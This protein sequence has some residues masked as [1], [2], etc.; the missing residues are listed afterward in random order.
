MIDEKIL[1]GTT[2]GLWDVGNGECRRFEG[3]EVQSLSRDDSGLMAIID[4]QQIWQSRGDAEW[5]QIAT[6]ETLNAVCLLSTAAGILVGTSEARLFLLRDGTLQPVRSFDSVEDRGN[7][8]TPWGGPPNVRSMAADPSGSLYVNVH[9]GG[10]VRSSDELESWQHTIDI[11]ADVHQVLHDSGSSMLLAATG[12][13]FAISADNGE[14]WGFHTEGLHG[15][16][17]RAI[18]VAGDTVLITASTG[19][20]TRKSAVYRRAV[21]SEE[22]F[23]RCRGGLPEWFSDNINTFC[24]AALDSSVAFGTTDGQVYYSSDEGR[25]WNAI[26]EEIPRILCVDITRP[27]I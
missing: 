14:S 9:V 20:S 19:P 22:G 12:I 4:G 24:L 10:I 23:E 1:L 11:D 6:L 2:D 7:W 13:G 16:Y 15:T 17:S 5:T 27:F 3:R 25:S 8:Y 18:A 26:A 21:N